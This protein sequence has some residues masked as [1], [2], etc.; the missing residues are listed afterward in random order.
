MA[1]RTG[2]EY[3]PDDVRTAT[4]KLPH[5]KWEDFQAICKGQGRS[6]S[7]ALLEFVESILNGGDIPGG[8]I[9]EFREEI[10]A[11]IAAINARLE[12][13]E[14][15]RNTK[16]RKPKQRPAQAEIEAVQPVDLSEKVNE[17]QP[18]SEPEPL[19]AIFTE[20]GEV[21]WTA[22]QLAERLKRSEQNVFQ[23]K[24]QPGFAEWCK[25]L[26]PDK[27][28]WENRPPAGKKINKLFPV[29]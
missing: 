24:T 5:H 12:A 23:R 20:V 3:Q 15:A 10:S 2:K 9:E 25:S 21:G 7:D 17:V 16:P 29:L 22:K 27:V 19:P 8:G 11:A 18:G 28:A 14:S 6:A 1:R 13:L 26:D 4:F